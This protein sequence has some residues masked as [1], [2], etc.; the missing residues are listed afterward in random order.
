MLPFGFLLAA[1]AA[2]VSN[3]ALRAVPEPL[4]RL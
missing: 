4:T 3:I 2:P 1:P